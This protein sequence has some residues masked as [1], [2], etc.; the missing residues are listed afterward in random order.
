MF[1]RTFF[2]MVL[3]FTLAGSGAPDRQLSFTG[4]VI[5]CGET[6]F[7]VK[8]KDFE[9]QFVLTADTRVITDRGQGTAADL[10][11]CQQVTVM[12]GEEAGGKVAREV[13]ILKPG[14]CFQHA[15]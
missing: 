15:R 1:L 6:F 4:R 11:L 2:V 10:E 8:K 3:T 14:D 7:E 5:Y 13:R 12:Y 9:V